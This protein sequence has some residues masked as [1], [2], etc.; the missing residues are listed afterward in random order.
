MSVRLDRGGD[1][2]VLE[3]NVTLPENKLQILWYDY[4]TSDEMLQNRPVQL[5]W[6]VT[7]LWMNSC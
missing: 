6:Q 4:E 2:S 5:G 1:A 3:L 7:D